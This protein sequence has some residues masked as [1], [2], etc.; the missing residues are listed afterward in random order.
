MPSAS[1][2]P[3]LLRRFK[4]PSIKRKLCPKIIVPSKGFHPSLDC[5]LEMRHTGMGTFAWVRTAK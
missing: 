1:S 4:K 5:T 3:F 2:D